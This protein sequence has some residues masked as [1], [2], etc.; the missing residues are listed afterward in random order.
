MLRKPRPLYLTGRV[1]CET[2]APISNRKGCSCPGRIIITKANV[3]HIA[4]DGL[5]QN[6]VSTEIGGEETG[7]CSDGVEEFRDGK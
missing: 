6:V 7:G 1:A 2:K 3:S 4:D 5:E